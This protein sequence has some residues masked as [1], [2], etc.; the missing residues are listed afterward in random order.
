MKRELWLEA[1]KVDHSD[2]EKWK[3]ARSYHR[4]N[5]EPYCADCLRIRDERIA[6]SKTP[7]QPIRHGTHS[8]YVTHRRRGE[9]ACEPCRIAHAEYAHERYW[10]SR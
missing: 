7:R 8:G 3:S 10:D 9:P 1:V 5:G 6:R 2:P 4:R